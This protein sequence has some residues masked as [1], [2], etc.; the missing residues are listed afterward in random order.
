VYSIEKYVNLTKYLMKIT[1]VFIIEAD[2]T[3]KINIYNYNIKN[4][5]KV[6]LNIRKIYN[7]FILIRMCDIDA[8]LIFTFQFETVYFF[9]K[10]INR[11]F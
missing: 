4:S 9:L 8:L 2:Q 5:E 10:K 7:F 11:E 1:I 6:Y 3:S